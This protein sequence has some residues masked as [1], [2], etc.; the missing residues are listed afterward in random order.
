[1]WV[2]DFIHSYQLFCFYSLLLL[3]GCVDLRLYSCRPTKPVSWWEDSSNILG[4]R[5]GLA[6]GTWLGCTRDGRLAFLTNFREPD[7]MPKA[8][9]RGELPVRFLEVSTNQTKLLLVYL[10]ICFWMV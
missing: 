6:G 9:S 3:V 5:D 1:M 8:K 7:S 4:G 2:L 10:F